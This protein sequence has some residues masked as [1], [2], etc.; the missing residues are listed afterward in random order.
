[1]KNGR[2]TVKN[3]TF[4]KYEEQPGIGQGSIKTVK[5]THWRNV[6]FYLNGC[7]KID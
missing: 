1:M 3:I 4:P 2:K 7:L 6:S 5:K